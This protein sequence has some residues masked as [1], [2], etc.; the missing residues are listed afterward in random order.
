MLDGELISAKDC[1]DN[2]LER[3]LASMKL[4]DLH[5]D[6]K[7]IGRG[8]F[9]TVHEATHIPS[10]TRLAVKQMLRKHIKGK[11]L[12]ATKREIAIHQQLSHP[13]IVRMYAHL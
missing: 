6:E 3:Q 9:G 1:T 10:G 12:E 8:T 5:I 4:S 7:C 2:A 11:Y 13:K